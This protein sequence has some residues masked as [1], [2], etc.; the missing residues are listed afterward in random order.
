MTF[1]EVMLEENRCFEEPAFEDNHP[2]LEF[3]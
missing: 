2:V 1:E 3:H